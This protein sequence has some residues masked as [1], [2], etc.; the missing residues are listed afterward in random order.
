M[1][2][3]PYDYA[4]CATPCALADKCRRT[5]P[6]RADYQAYTKYEG[7]EDCRGFWPEDNGK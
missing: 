4:R 3:L 7:G 2:P 6:G 1:T 5:T